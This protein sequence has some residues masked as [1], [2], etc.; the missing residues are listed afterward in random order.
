[1]PYRG[2]WRTGRL[3][4]VHDATMQ[5]WVGMLRSQQISISVADDGSQT[6]DSTITLEREAA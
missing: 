6:W 3:V 5:P 1:M 2:L 4:S